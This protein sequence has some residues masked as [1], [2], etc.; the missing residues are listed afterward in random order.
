MGRRDEGR[1]KR[2]KRGERGEEKD[3]EFNFNKVKF[4]DKYGLYIFMRHI[5]R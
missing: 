3:R 4:L 2:R 5:P 1:R